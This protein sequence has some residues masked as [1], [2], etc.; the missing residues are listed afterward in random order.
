MPIREEPMAMP[1]LGQG[2]S[3][4]RFV[5]PSCNT[6]FHDESSYSGCS[7]EVG[8]ESPKILSYLSVLKLKGENQ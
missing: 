7:F 2:L 4:A 8:E 1:N 6:D 5:Q 3:L